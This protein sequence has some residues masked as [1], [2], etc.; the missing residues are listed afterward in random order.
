MIDFF[1]SNYKP[2]FRMI[3]IVEPFEV[4]VAERLFCVGREG[5]ERGESKIAEFPE[6]RNILL[7]LSFKVFPIT[8]AI[9]SN[10]ASFPLDVDI[11]WVQTIIK[12]FLV[13]HS[14]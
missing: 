12:I 5:F 1:S 10:L 4:W 8:K 13:Q 14:D 9:N 7:W 6:I 2:K 11:I 3:S